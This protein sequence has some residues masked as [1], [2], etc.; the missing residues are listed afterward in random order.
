VAP[1]RGRLGFADVGGG[2]REGLADDPELVL[3]Q[4][5]QRRGEPPAGS[6]GQSLEQRQQNGG[7]ALG[8]RK[9][10]DVGHAALL[11]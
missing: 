9:G 7:E 6:R 5:D 4:R 3:D 2:E 10:W 11:V 8:R 1:A